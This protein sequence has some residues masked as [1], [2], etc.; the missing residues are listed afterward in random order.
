M[1]SF[2]A[3]A[4]K[5]Q[6]VP[7]QHD[8]KLWAMR[9]TNLEPT[10]PAGSTLLV[11]TPWRVI[12]RGDIVVFKAPAMNLP[13]LWVLRVGWVP[14]DILPDSLQQDDRSPQLPDSH[15]W[16]QGGHRAL[17]SRHFGPIPVSAIRGIVL[18]LLHD[19]PSITIER[20]NDPGPF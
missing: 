18:G 9:G 16:L 3:P 10:V 6:L 15:Y 20:I 1:G 19:G 8:L 17:D 11:Q 4:G 2:G 7:W 12:H 14:G 13:Y 5:E